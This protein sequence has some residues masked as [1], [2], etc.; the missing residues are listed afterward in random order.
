M[1]ESR[2][3]GGRQWEED[4]GRGKMEKRDK[5]G[6]EWGKWEKGVKWGMSWR[7]R[8]RMEEDAVEEG[9]IRMGETGKWQ[10]GTRGQRGVAVWDEGTEG[11][12]TVGRRDREGGSVGRGERKGWQCGTRGH[13]GWQCGTRGQRELAV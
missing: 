10:C 3:G 13:R 12:G 11:G 1:E 9:D 8:D 2:E 7:S 4:G 6:R 5:E